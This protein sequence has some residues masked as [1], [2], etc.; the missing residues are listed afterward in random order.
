LGDPSPH[1]NCGAWHIAQVLEALTT[2]PEVWRMTA[3]FI[4]F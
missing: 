3:A 4:T 2:D 1:A